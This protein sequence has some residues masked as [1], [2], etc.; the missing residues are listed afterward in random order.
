MKV[1]LFSVFLIPQTFFFSVKNLKLQMELSVFSDNAHR[2]R[3]VDICDAMSAD[4]VQYVKANLSNWRQAMPNGKTGDGLCPSLLGVACALAR[5]NVVKFLLDV[6]FDPNEKCA[7]DKRFPLLITKRADVT[8]LL[9][10]H[11]ANAKMTTD[12]GCNAMCFSLF[13]ININLQRVSVLLDA[14]TR[15]PM[16]CCEHKWAVAG[17]A[18][19]TIITDYGV[20]GQSAELGNVH[21]IPQCYSDLIRSMSLCRRAVFQFLCI[22]RYHKICHRDVVQLIVRKVWDTRFDTEVWEEKKQQKK[23]K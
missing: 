13:T 22:C 21:Q 12:T 8:V 17:V 19:D 18:I 9:L 20:L 23:Q 11:G 14:G 1:S 15:L 7:S 10:K 4:N 2:K 16:Q 3:F 5:C 6:G